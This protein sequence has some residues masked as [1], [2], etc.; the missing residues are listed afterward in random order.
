MPKFLTFFSIPIF[1]REINLTIEKNIKS[2][3]PKIALK[4]DFALLNWVQNNWNWSAQVPQRYGPGFGLKNWIILA[5]NWPKRGGKSGG[6]EKNIAFGVLFDQM[7]EN[8]YLLIRVPSGKTIFH[9]ESPISEVK[10]LRATSVLGWVTARGE[11]VQLRDWANSFF[12][13]LQ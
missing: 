11:A 3:L 1:F 8:K 10:Q 12:F 9:G 6:I 4:I 7:L 5:Q 2:E 13:L